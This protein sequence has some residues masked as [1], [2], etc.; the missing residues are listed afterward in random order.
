MGRTR[1]GC[2]GLLTSERASIKALSR[3]GLSAMWRFIIALEVVLPRLSQLAGT[4]FQACLILISSQRTAAVVKSASNTAGRKDSAKSQW[5]VSTGPV[6]Y[7]NG[8]QKVNY[9]STGA[10]RMWPKC[11]AFMWHFIVRIEVEA[12]LKRNYESDEKRHPRFLTEPPSGLKRNGGFEGFQHFK[13]SFS[14]KN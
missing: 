8:V 14:S 1:L 7:E 6:S 2:L 12:R 13:C 4:V 10:L 3:S 9:L 5:Y 11:S